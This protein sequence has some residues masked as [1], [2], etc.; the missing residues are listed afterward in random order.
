MYTC[1]RYGGDASAEAIASFIAFRDSVGL[2]MY[3]GE[4]GHN[5]E[6]WMNHFTSVMRENNIGYTFWPYKKINDSSM[7][8]VQ[9]P[10]DWEKLVTFVEAPRGSYSEIRDARKLCSQEEASAMLKQY[11]ENS[12]AA[13]MLKH[14]GYIKAIDL[15]K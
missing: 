11:V 13:N 12:R 1:H 9:Q 6:E 7:T 5:T 3:M 8:G 15:K 14:E 4:I 2:P 10:Q